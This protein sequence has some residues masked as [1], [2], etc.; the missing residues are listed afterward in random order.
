MIYK[1][2]LVQIIVRIIGIVLLSF[3]FGWLLWESNYPNL[4]IVVFILICWQVVKLIYFLNSTNR[5][6]SQFFL[7]VKN[8][9]STLKIPKVFEGRSFNELRVSMQNVNQIIKDLRLKFQQKEIFSDAIIENA[10]VGILTIT[11]SG[12]VECINRKG[13]ELLGVHHLVNIKALLKSDSNLVFLFQQIK[14]GE[15]RIVET[16]ISQTKMHLLVNC[17][18]LILAE[19]TYQLLSF[20]DIKNQLDAKELES[21]Q[22]LINVLTHEIMNSVSPLTCLS[23]NLEKSYKEINSGTLISEKLLTKTKTGLR[24]IKEQGEGLM[25]FVET[26]R[27]LSR[28]PKPQIK[29]VAVK[30]LFEHV[31]SL[32]CLDENVNI[33]YQFIIEGEDLLIAIDEQLIVQVMVNLIKNAQFAIFEKG[34]IQ[35]KAESNEDGFVIISIEDNGSG[36]KSEDMQSVFIPFFTTK[37]NGSGIGLSIARSIMRLHNGNI[38]LESFY[39]EGTRVLISFRERIQELSKEKML[40]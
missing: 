14:S 17:S 15:S 18:A 33:H 19:E 2:L 26:Y 7:S 40:V 11:S 25:H 9:D 23:E 21:W 1:K 35:I 12:K 6:L 3:L 39:G 28:I 38:N 20:T 34:I 27:E 31:K 29:D 32:F 24:V 30:H 37:E 16:Q 36:I 13:R 4:S 8:E 5:L 10:A 22:S